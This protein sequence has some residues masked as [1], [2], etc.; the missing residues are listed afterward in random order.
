M[1]DKDFIP[2][3]AGF[4]WAKTDDFK[5]FNAIVHVVGTAPF[6][7]IEGWNHHKEKQ[8]TDLSI[9]SEWGPKIESP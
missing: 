2:T 9:I 3:E 4:Y 7:R 8:F 6:F 1:A 5:W